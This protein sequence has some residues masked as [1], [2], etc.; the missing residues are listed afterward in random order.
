MA[1]AGAGARPSDAMSTEMDE[2]TR[3]E[4]CE[5]GG[6]SGDELSAL[7]DMPS[8]GVVVVDRELRIRSANPAYA[9]LVMESPERLEGRRLEEVAPL[10]AG[11]IGAAVT[12]ALRSSAPVVGAHVP[13]N[14]AELSIDVLPVDARGRDPRAVVVVS[15]T[16]RRPI[17][18]DDGA[19]GARRAF[20]DIARHMARATIEEAADAVVGTLRFAV[21]TYRLDR[22]YVRLLTDDEARY[23]T[24]HEYDRAGV[25]PLGTPEISSASIA[26][27]AERFARGEIV[28]LS[29]RDE[30]P[31][32]QGDFRAAL[33]RVG[34]HATIGVPVLDGPRV[35]G[36]VAYP[37]SEGRAWT[38]AEVDL[39][40][41]LGEMIAAVV[42]RTRAE[43]RI[44]SWER[45]FAQV[46]ESAMDGVVIVDAEGVVK[47]WT[48]QA[49]NVLGRDRE[50]MLGAGLVSVIH[51][52]DRAAL[53]AKLTTTAGAGG[54]VQRFELRGLRADGR[55]VPVELS[56]TRLDRAEGVLVASFVRDIT[57]R[58]RIEAEKQRA[59]DEVSRQKRSL[60]RERDYLREEQGPSAILGESPAIRRAIELCEAV[61]DTMSSVL[62]L[63]ESG[64]GKELF[65]AAVHAGSARAGGPFVKV[66]CASV[67]GSLFESEF[68]G[69]AKGSFTGAVKDRIGRFELA[70]GG[71][72]FLDEVGEIPVELQAKLLR[73][74]QEGEIERVGEDRTRRLDVRVVA[75]TNRDLP[76]EVAAGHFRRDLYF[77]LGVF[78]IAVPSLRERGADVLLLARHFLERHAA[79]AR[80]SG[81]S[82]SPDDEARLLAYDWPGNVRELDHVIERA[83]IL[84]RA[85][86]LRLDLA[87]P[88]RDAGRPS[89]PAELLQEDD[90]RRIER[91]NL[92]LALKRA[93]GRVSG[94]GGAAEL[95]GMRPSTLRDRMKTLGISRED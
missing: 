8:S 83:V 67:P 54:A 6:P 84:S 66:N 62:L 3:R 45:R 27:A 94:P 50:E 39:L 28:V 38:G 9:H 95:L 34:I 32:D 1:G 90:L 78:P 85:P 17:A 63:G 20:F 79:T 11:A 65:A 29:S 23:R 51:A 46:L 52:G 18:G 59:F 56:M 15:D 37:A 91:D 40:R 24:S 88:L 49:T 75:A 53:A 43:E 36:Y 71:T 92:V 47:D 89:P 60:E 12:S 14:F 86:P 7:W 76:R 77:R 55:V 72:L 73:V 5:A 42:V 70:D 81:L 16:R 2:S 61:A 22:A 30:I 19:S 21:E 33:D 57:D 13:Y 69:H 35:L 25:P 74:L 87:L 93:G 10:T 68:F 31:A 58:K 41:L 80:R 26:W 44:R 64:V 82:L 48:G 4:R